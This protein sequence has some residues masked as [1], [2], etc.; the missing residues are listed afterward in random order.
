[1]Y[2]AVSKTTAC[3]RV[4]AISSV[5]ALATVPVIVATGRVVVAPISGI[6]AADVAACRAG[7]DAAVGREAPTVDVVLAVAA[8]RR[9]IVTVAGAVVAVQPLTSTVTVRC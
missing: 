6:G 8:A 7:V 1:M 9:S 5:V 2:A 4:G 3:T